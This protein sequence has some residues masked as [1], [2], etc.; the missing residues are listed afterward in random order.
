MKYFV[1]L[2][3]PNCISRD[4]KCLCRIFQIPFAKAITLE[5]QKWGWIRWMHMWLVIEWTLN[6]SLGP[7]MQK[8]FNFPVLLL[9]L[10]LNLLLQ[11][12]CEPESLTGLG[13]KKM[14]LKLSSGYS[15][16]NR[17]LC[18][19]FW[20]VIFAF[21]IF[22]NVGLAKHWWKISQVGLRSW[23]KEKGQ[24]HLFSKNSLSPIPWDFEVQWPALTLNLHWIYT[25]F[26]C[27]LV[28]RAVVLQNGWEL[29]HGMKSKLRHLEMFGDKQLPSTL[30][31]TTR[32]LEMD[33]HN[34]RWVPR[35]VSDILMYSVTCFEV[36]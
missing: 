13:K 27:C 22:C 6:H 10:V 30:T 23:H 28:L 21:G 32:A 9:Y 15:G 8:N 31:M 5:R 34:W 26:T 20:R 25:A 7:V 19:R 33:S 36:Q 2:P 11:R 12:C 24:G 4:G 14:H 29:L 1:F 18:E 35:A 16:H 3:S 17:L